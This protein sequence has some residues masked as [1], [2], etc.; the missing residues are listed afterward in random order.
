MNECKRKRV[1]L[2]FCFL[3]EAKL[4][5]KL[6]NPKE[7]GTRLFE[8]WDKKEKEKEKKQKAKD[9]FIMC[10]SKKWYFS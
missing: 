10:T 7:K 3:S 9:Y 5:K 1:L 4:L 6:Q 2:A 8:T